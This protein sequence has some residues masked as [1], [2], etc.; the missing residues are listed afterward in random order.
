MFHMTAPPLERPGFLCVFTLG[1]FVLV[2]LIRY[3]QDIKHRFLR[4]AMRLATR[5]FHP[6]NQADQHIVYGPDSLSE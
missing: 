3:A 2:L 4:E 5:S 6:L 1:D